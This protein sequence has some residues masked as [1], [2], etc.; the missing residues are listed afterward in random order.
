LAGTSPDTA[1]GGREVFKLD[2]GAAGGFADGP[3]IGGEDP[4][5][6]GAGESDVVSLAIEDDEVD[7]GQAGRLFEL[8][9]DWFAGSQKR[10]DLLANR[11]QGD[12]P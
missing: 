12:L 9:W 11:L 1:D 6:G 8:G 4:S 2:D 10:A 3:A 7:A 5:L